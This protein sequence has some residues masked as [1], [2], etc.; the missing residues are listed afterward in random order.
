MHGKRSSHLLRAALV[1]W[2]V[3]TAQKKEARRLEQQLVERHKRQTTAAALSNW[4][5]QTAALAEAREAANKMAARSALKHKHTA[6]TSHKVL[7]RG[8][9]KERHV[10]STTCLG[11]I[12]GQQSVLLAAALLSRSLERV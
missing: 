6:L 10:T 3:R 4:R 7:R 12:C 11:K 9:G 5:E 1:E 8:L 2:A